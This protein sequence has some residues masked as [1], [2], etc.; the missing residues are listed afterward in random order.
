[1]E[2]FTVLYSNRRTICIEVGPDGRLT[3]RAP[4]SMRNRE[5]EQFVKSRADWIVRA[6]RRQ[7]DRSQNEYRKTPT[8][9]EAAALK[10]K[11]CAYIPPRVEYF[12]ER[13]GLYPSAIKISSAA[14]RFGSCSAKNSLNFSWRLMRY[15]AEAIDYVIVHELAHIRH[16][17][18]GKEFY[19]LI[20]RYLPDYKKRIAILKQ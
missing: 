1:M 8:A 19:A 16:R 10:E 13:M 2:D 12:A 6:R 3:V 11:A 9:A 4:Y 17:N 15:P 18:H 20:G 5:I 7:A 14:T